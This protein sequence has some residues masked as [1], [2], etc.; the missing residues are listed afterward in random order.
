MRFSHHD[1]F[2]WFA[3]Q[4][5]ALTEYVASFIVVVQPFTVTLEPSRQAFYGGWVVSIAEQQ[6]V[7]YKLFIL[8]LLSVILTV[9]F[10]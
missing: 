3:F 1:I 2:V 4:A 8:L 7:S 5:D 6:R 9:Y 10:L